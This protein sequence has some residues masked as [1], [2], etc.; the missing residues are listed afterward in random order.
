MPDQERLQRGRDYEHRV[1]EALG[2]R[3][4]AGSGNQ[5]H[6][7]GDV[8]GRLLASAKAESQKSWSRVREQLR[9]A[10]DMA[11]GTGAHPML[12]L[13][14]DDGD[15][16][17]VMYLTD[18]AQALADGVPGDGGLSRGDLVRQ[19]ADTPTMLRDA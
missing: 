19:R 4:V 10:K 14:E 6:S 17:V 2:G 1:R 3:L 13:L 5:W 11:F 8:R 15:E 12:A 7:R 18:F 16:I 9:E